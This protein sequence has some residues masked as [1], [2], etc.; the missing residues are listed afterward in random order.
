MMIGSEPSANNAEPVP[1]Q[2]D[3]FVFVSNLH[4]ASWVFFEN[5][6]QH[7]CRES[8]LGGVPAAPTGPRS[9]PR[10]QPH[11]LPPAWVPLPSI[12]CSLLP[13]T[14]LVQ[15]LCLIQQCL[16]F[17]LFWMPLYCRG[18]QAGSKTDALALFS[19]SKHETGEFSLV[20]LTRDRRLLCWTV[21]T[22]RQTVRHLPTASVAHSLTLHSFDWKV[23]MFYIQQR[24]AS[25]SIF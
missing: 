15:C 25:W 19:S 7:V 18:G 9:T 21:S 4:E 22:A 12:P 11:Q 17:W 23:A 8:G 5:T 16:C 2:S 1:P 14:L 20:T 10:A 24:S 6:Y 13:S 3:L